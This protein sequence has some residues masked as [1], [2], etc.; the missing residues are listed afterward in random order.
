[1]KI[2][3]FLISIFLVSVSMMAEPIG[4]DEARVKAASFLNSTSSVQRRANS[5][6][7]SVMSLQEV[8]TDFDYLYVFN[9]VET[10]GFVVVS[11]DDKT[12]AVLAYSESGSFDSQQGNEALKNMLA[13]LNGEVAAVAV[14]PFFTSR[15]DTEYREQDREPVY[16]LITTCWHQYQ[17]YYGFCPIDPNNGSPTLV[18]CVAITLAQLMKYYKVHRL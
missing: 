3:S 15:N 11:A 12:D 17:P 18:G 2:V 4:I 9:N 5:V 10:G 7:S 1:M 13:G 14:S 6:C 8:H 16:P